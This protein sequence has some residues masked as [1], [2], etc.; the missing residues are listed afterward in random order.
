MKES[1]PS[2]RPLTA[3][4]L[5]IADGWTTDVAAAALDTLAAMLDGPPPQRERGLVVVRGLPPLRSTLLCRAR[6]LHR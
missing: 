2:A 6:R 4:A 5:G 3:R 1:S